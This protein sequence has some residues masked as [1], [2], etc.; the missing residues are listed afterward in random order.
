MTSYNKPSSTFSTIFKRK[1]LENTCLENM[2]MV[3]DAAIYESPDLR[4]GYLINS[5]IGT[6]HIH[7]N[8]ITKYLSSNFIIEN[9]DEKKK[10]FFLAKEN[11]IH[12]GNDWLKTQFLITINY[13]FENNKYSFLTFVKFTNGEFKI[14]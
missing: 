11:N 3:N 6:Y 1:I 14:M 8:N 10:I 12:L 9:L 2:K 7:E 4:G 13:Y 5:V